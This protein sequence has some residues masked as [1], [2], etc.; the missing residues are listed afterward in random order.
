LRSSHHFLCRFAGISATTIPGLSPVAFQ[1]EMCRS[2]SD[3]HSDNAA[4]KSE[5]LVF[6]TGAF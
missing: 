5:P 4:S 1:S 6:D 3:L 2:P